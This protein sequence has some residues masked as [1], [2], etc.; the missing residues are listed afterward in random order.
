L[1]AMLRRSYRSNRGGSPSGLPMPLPGAGGH[2]ERHRL[3]HRGRGRMTGKFLRARVPV[4]DPPIGVGDHFRYRR[5]GS[6]LLPQRAIGHT[7]NSGPHP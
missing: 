7:S 3:A 4:A 2:D 6:G 5:S 1:A